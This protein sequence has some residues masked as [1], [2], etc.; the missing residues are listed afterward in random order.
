MGAEPEGEAFRPRPG[1]PGRRGW[2][3]FL[4]PPRAA[5]GTD[6][7]QRRLRPEEEE[8]KRLEQLQGRKQSPESQ[9][10]GL[11]IGWEQA[12]PLAEGSCFRA[13]CHSR[14]LR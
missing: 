9:G 8:R 10:R 6:E 12:R 1:G 3:V 4:L 5:E 14:L 13:S 11:E 2:R 7:G